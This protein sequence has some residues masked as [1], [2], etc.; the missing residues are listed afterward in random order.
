MRRVDHLCRSEIATDPRLILA[1]HHTYSSV[2]LIQRSLALQ[3]VCD[4]RDMT[5]AIYRQVLGS[6]SVQ[7]SL[8][9]S[10]DQLC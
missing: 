1:G 10:C 4:L 9:G 5:S 8:I 2:G 6:Q 7:V 3:I